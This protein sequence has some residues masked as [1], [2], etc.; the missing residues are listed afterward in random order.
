[1][2]LYPKNMWLHVYTDGS[3]QDDCSAG[4]SFYCKNL[5]EGSLAA[6]LGVTNFDAKVESVRQAIY[7]LTNLSTSYRKAVFLVDSQSVIITL[8]SLR[9][10]D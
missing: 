10:S 5:F 2:T 8:C 3:A 6:S 7:H 9:N 4:A 1:M